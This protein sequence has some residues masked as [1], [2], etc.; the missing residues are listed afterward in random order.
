MKKAWKWILG[1]VVLLVV[2]FAV[3]FVLYNIWGGGIRLAR[4][5]FN[6]RGPMMGNEYNFRHPMMGEGF[7]FFR[8]PAMGL[9][10]FAPF[11][12]FFFLGGLLRLIFPL[13]LLALVAYIFYRMG[14]KAGLTT[15]SAPA[16]AAPSATPTTAPAAEAEET[17]QSE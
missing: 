7:N 17:P 13:G 1:I 15:S 5:P 6:G 4:V 3:G 16:A 8:R 10:G 12:A 11:G 14:K 9:R 2:L